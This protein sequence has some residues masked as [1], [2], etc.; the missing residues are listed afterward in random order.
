VE[1]T[2]SAWRRDGV[3]GEA[4]KKTLAATMGPAATSGY[5]CAGAS[6]LRLHG[7]F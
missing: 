3:Q 5:A 4:R 2:R 1:A 6:I 7:Y